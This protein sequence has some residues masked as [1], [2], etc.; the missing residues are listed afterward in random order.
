M[1]LT[2]PPIASMSIACSKELSIAPNSSFTAMR[3][4]WKTRLAGCPPF[5]RAGAGIASL[6]K[7][8]N[9]PVVSIGLTSR[10][11][12]IKRAICLENFSSP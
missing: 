9:S 2:L 5:R 4:A 6:I 7:S 8:T 11:R 3:M 12:S 1:T 10:L